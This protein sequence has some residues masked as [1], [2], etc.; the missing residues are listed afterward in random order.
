MYSHVAVGFISAESYEEMRALTVPGYQ[1]SYNAVALSTENEVALN[2]V[3]VLTSDEVIKNIPGYA[4]EQM[5][6][7]MIL[8]V[9]VVI[10]A[11]ILGIFFYIL[12]LQK[13][14]QF[15]VLK[16]IGMKM[17]EINGMMIAQILLLSVCGAVI[18]NLLAFLMASFLPAAM[19]FYLKVPD[20]ALV[21]AVFVMIS[22]VFGAFST[23]YV[24]KV[25]PLMV[26]GGA[27]NE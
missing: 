20:A 22:L 15:G 14:S 24:A 12:T 3:T 1:L 11:I 13:Q 27:E 9:L 7:Q 18:G 21:S 10:S 16:A 2:G 5:T 6:I 25:D 26:I 4:A 23:R 8:W 17:R 19:P